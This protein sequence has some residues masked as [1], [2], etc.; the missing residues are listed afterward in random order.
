[1]RITNTASITTLED[2]NLSMA[3]LQEA[4]MRAHQEIEYNLRYQRYPSNEL[5]APHPVLYC[6]IVENEAFTIG[7]FCIPAG[8]MIP[9]HD[10]PS[11]TV[12]SKLVK[13]KLHI[14]VIRQ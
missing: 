13:G 4:L 6:G 9:L 3:K 10:H 14:K 8:G 11:M 2:I 5:S 7:V 12:S 1:M